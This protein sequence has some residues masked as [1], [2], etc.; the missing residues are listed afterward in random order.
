MS[1]NTNYSASKNLNINTRDL[2]LEILIEINERG[3]FSHIVLRSVLDKYQYLPKQER[4]FITRLVDGTIEYMLQ[5]D[6]IIDSFSKTKVRKMKPLIRNLLR[7][8]VY[9]IKYMDSVPDSAVCNEAVKIA[10]R[11]KFGQLSGF[12][13]GVLRNIARNV[14]EIEFSNLSVR[15][16]M[17]QWI[18]DQFVSSYG[19]KKVEEIFK[20]FQTKSTISIRT[21]LSACTPEELKERLI[22]ESVTATEVLELDYAFMISDFDHLGGLASFKEGL[23]Y[24]QDVSSMMV[25]E[26]AAP[27]PGDYVIDVCAAPGGKS[28][29][30]AEKL[31]GT[32]HVKARDLTDY[33]VDM[34]EE[35]IERHGLT[36]MSAEVFDATEYDE[37]SKETADIVICDLPCSGL[38]VLGRK[39]DIRYKMSPKG[40]D[41]LAALQR[42][43]LD[44]VHTYVKP[45]GVLVYS[46]CTIDEK[47]NEKNV[48]WF[49]E[50]YPQ[51]SL[52]KT[53]FNGKGMEQM[54]PGEHGN[55]GFF[56][57]RLIRG[58]S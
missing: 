27:K 54:L 5:L 35:N 52:D 38:G 17:P 33:K 37:K 43:I 28:T 55:D 53:F 29:H 14:D 6:Y 39:K 32:G 19:D 24:V 9:Q 13:N 22:A 12:V 11:H 1:N 7:M 57:A 3:Q 8:S 10:K 45:G 16:S 26:T 18:V 23:F 2:A 46:T 36:N 34:I 49:L 21:N 51:Y 15:Y 42:Q 40:I 30:I 58:A 41:D 47:E 56:I 50:K 31:K 48:Q 44:T 20:N 4:A 25:A